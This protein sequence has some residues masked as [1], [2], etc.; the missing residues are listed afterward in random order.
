MRGL[1]G[2]VKS[3][4]M[5]RLTITLTEEQA[6]RIEELSGDGGPYGSKSEAVRNLIQTG[7][8][9]EELETKVERLERE[10]RLLLE[11]REE[12]RELVRYV[13]DERSWRSASLPRRVKWWVFGKDEP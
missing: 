12:K 10:K 2:V 3:F 4:I 13:E 1:T 5:S 9:V 11:E 7:E 8:R 6:E